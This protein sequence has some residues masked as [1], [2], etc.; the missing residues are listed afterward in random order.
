MRL[1]KKTFINLDEF[2]EFVAEQ[3]NGK[4]RLRIIPV[5]VV[6]LGQISGLRIYYGQTDL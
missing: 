2:N 1:Y 6:E 4:R 3:R 5:T